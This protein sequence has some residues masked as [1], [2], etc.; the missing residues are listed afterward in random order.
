MVRR[1]SRTGQTIVEATTVHVTNK[2]FEVRK[3][4]FRTS[5]IDLFNG[6]RRE[7]AAK[8]L[9]IS[10]GRHGIDAG[11]SK[12]GEVSGEEGAGDQDRDRGAN[13]KRIVRLDAKQE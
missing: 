12:C 3:T 10:Q 9:F 7:P 4:S 11:G 1:L 5:R 6:Y 8:A 2:L 13:R